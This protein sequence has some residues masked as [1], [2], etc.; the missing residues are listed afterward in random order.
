MWHTRKCSAVRGIIEAHCAVVESENKNS[1]L[2]REDAASQLRVHKHAC[3][4]A[5]AHTHTHSCACG[6][7]QAESQSHTFHHAHVVIIYL[8]KEH[9]K[10]QRCDYRAHAHRA[11]ELQRPIVQTLKTPEQQ[12]DRCLHRMN[13]TFQSEFNREPAVLW[14]V[15]QLINKNQ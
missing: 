13:P 5:H 6:L 9:H 3:V 7:M 15:Q 14:D 11:D 12:T 2:H 10:V 1:A 4:R 8:Q